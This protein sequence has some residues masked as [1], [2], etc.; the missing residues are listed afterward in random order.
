[1]DGGKPLLFFI[2]QHIRPIS[3]EGGAISSAAVAP[4]AAA[5]VV[6]NAI[7]PYLLSGFETHPLVV[8]SS[9][10]PP[11]FDEEPQFVIPWRVHKRPAFLDIVPHT[12]MTTTNSE[13]E[14]DTKLKWRLAA[15]CGKSRRRCRPHTATEQAAA[16]HGPCWAMPWAVWIPRVH[17]GTRFGG[18][19]LVR[20]PTPRE[21]GI[22]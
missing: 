2:A 5:A 20:R 10:L 1:M 9:S 16:A 21:G 12:Y 17:R 7:P 3:S 19:D 18:T 11:R 4:S 15:G 13:L 22:C 14:P 6:V 8:G